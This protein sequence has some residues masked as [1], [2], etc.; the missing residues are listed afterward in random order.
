M[1]PMNDTEN[2]YLLL[3]VQYTGSERTV[4]RREGWGGMGRCGK[5]HEAA[6]GR[7]EEEEEEEQR[8]G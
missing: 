3:L 8:E 2:I 6:V 7:G 5:L 4:C 1:P